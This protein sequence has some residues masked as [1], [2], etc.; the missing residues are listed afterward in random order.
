MGMKQNLFS[1]L[2]I[3]LFLEILLSAL[4]LDDLADYGEF[5]NVSRHNLA[6]ETSV[7]RIS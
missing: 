3:W 6:V 4:N 1:K 7:V 5:L 2:F